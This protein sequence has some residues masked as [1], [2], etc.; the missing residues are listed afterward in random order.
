MK[1]HHSRRPCGILDYSTTASATDIPAADAPLAC[2]EAPRR[3]CWQNTAELAARDAELQA[4]R[5][6]A[7]ESLQAAQLA[8][9]AA[10]DAAATGAAAAVAGLAAAEAAEAAAQRAAALA[11]EQAAALAARE[12]ELTECERGLQERGGGG[13]GGG[14]RGVGGLRGGGRRPD[15]RATQKERDGGLCSKVWEA[16]CTHD[17]LSIATVSRTVG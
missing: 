3:A 5:K 11:E 17:G 7:D 16:W 6:Q 12:A 10:D 9:S 4:V 14:S 13:G 2:R 15:P 8:A 1:A